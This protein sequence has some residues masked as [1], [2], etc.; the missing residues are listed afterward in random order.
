M[1]Y[2][3]ELNLFSYNYNAEDA[4]EFAARKAFSMVMYL[5]NFKIVDS[6]NNFFK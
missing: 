5:T 1:D 4:S 2:S 3:L 6:V